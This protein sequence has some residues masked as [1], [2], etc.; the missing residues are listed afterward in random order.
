MGIRIIFVV[1]VLFGLWFIIYRLRHLR[2]HRPALTTT[3]LT[4]W[5]I[6]LFLIIGV[7]LSKN[8]ELLWGLLM[9][10]PP[11]ILRVMSTIDRVLFF[12]NRAETIKNWWQTYQANGRS[13]QQSH[14]HQKV[15]TAAHSKQ[16]AWAIL[17][18]KPGA[19]KDDIRAAHRRLM[20]KVHP[21]RGGSDYLAARLNE[22]KQILLESD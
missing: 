2:Q 9:L 11:L 16:E 3:S 7:F 22:A 19:S 1:L 4:L 8:I 17:G 21:D 13:S 5:I 20:L 10:I 15:S 18:L 6:A 12:K 14:Q